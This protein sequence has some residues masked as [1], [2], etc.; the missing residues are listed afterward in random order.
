MAKVPS[1]TPTSSP[2]LSST[3]TPVKSSQSADSLVSDL[4][5][6][7]GHGIAPQGA[8]GNGPWATGIRLASSTDGITFSPT[9]DSLTDQASVPNLVQGNDKRLRCY[10][11]N[12]QGNQKVVAIQTAPG[13]WI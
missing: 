8:Q 5:P 7:V 3:P 1:Q 12:F 10:Y 2:K 11:I 4:T 6:S 9:G 13:K